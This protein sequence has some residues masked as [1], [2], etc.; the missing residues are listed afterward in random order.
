MPQQTRQE[1]KVSCNRKRVKTQEGVVV[2]ESCRQVAYS[3]VRPEMMASC[4]T[5]LVLTVVNHV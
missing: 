1:T 2:S 4:T 3:R 5:V